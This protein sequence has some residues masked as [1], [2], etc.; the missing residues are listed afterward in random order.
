MHTMSRY[1]IL[2]ICPLRIFVM[3][4][5]KRVAAVRSWIAIKTISLA[6]LPAVA[7]AQAAEPVQDEVCADDIIVTGTVVDV[8]LRQGASEISAGR[9]V[10]LSSDSIA[11]A[12]AFEPSAN[13]KIGRAHVELQSLM[14]IS[15]AVFCLKK[16]KT[17]N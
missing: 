9:V 12:L 6:I 2:F 8:R 1:T 13:A 5:R 4:L 16:K 15:Y 7:N 11:D 3:R 10:E 14:R 17:N